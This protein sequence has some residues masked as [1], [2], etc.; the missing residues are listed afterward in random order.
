[1]KFILSQ[2]IKNFI[3]FGPG[4][5]LK[6]LLRRIEPAAEVI[7]IEKKQ[8]ILSLTCSTA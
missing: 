2:G 4:K 6:G 1:M 7:S 5:V 3:E 8:D